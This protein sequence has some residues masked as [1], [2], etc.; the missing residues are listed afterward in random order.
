[1]PDETV[2]RFTVEIIEGDQ[3]GTLMIIDNYTC[4][5]FLQLPL[6]CPSLIDLASKE[7]GRRAATYIRKAI[8]G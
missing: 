6:D 5:T 1:M 3:T 4:R 2:I 7:V 8:E